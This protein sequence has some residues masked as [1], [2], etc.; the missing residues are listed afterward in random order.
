MG[1]TLKAWCWT[2]YMGKAEKIKGAIL[3]VHDSPFGCGKQR[4]DI[5][6]C[7]LCALTLWK[8]PC[9]MQLFHSSHAAASS[10]HDKIACFSDIGSSV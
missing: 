7:T 6:I 5:R 4:H 9:G 1:P 2:A 3:K 8:M 10:T